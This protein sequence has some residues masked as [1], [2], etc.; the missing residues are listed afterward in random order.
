MK[1]QMMSGKL[2]IMGVVGLILIAVFVTA[3]QAAI[4]DA[5]PAAPEPVSVKGDLKVVYELQISNTEK[6]GNG[7]NG[8]SCSDIEFHPEYLVVKSKMGGG[9]VIPVAR[10]RSFTWTGK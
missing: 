4:H 10:I 9:S 1:E 7:P 8:E 6:T 5:S 2:T 3:N